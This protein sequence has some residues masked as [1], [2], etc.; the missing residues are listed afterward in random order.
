MN[1]TA[2]RHPIALKRIVYRAPGMDTIRV[3]RDVEYHQSDAGPL[4]M[5]VYHPPVSGPE[6]VAPVV[7]IVTGYRDTGVPRPLGCAFKDME[8]SISLGQLLA[9]S[10]IAAVAYTTSDPAVDVFRAITY[11]RRNAGTL[12]IDSVRMGLWAMSGKVPV[13]LSVLMREDAEPIR[14]AVLSCGFT[15]DTDGSSVADSAR[16]YRFVNAAAGKSVADILPDTALFVSRAGCDEFPGLNSALDRFVADAVV[17]NLNLT[18]VNHATAPHG[19][20]LNDDSDATRYV[21][22]QMLGFVNFRLRVG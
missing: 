16:A 8:I 12:A 13:A 18:F 20:E 2:Q 7:M 9:A 10:G 17:R 5:D 11:V 4:L 1:D 19:F 6:N 14:A 15:V 21:I 22:Q 3:T